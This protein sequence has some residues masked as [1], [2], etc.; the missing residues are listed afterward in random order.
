MKIAALDVPGLLSLGTRVGVFVGGDGL[1]EGQMV[2]TMLF[3]NRPAAKR[4][5]VRVV[6]IASQAR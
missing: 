3:C 1:S 4:A 6:L 2:L 5:E